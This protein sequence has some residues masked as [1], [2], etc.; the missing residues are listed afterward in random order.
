[1]P[2][3]SLYL[4]YKPVTQVYFILSKHYRPIGLFDKAQYSA[5]RSKS[6]ALSRSS[7]LFNAGQNVVAQQ[8]VVVWQNGSVTFASPGRRCFCVRCACFCRCNSAL[9]RSFGRCGWNLEELR[10]LFVVS[11]SV[12]GCKRLASVAGP[13]FCRVSATLSVFYVV[14]SASWTMTY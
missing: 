12:R 9:R 5:A 4:H 6:A 3:H 8:K 14:K 13:P 10:A 7:W 11:R 1:M 2:T